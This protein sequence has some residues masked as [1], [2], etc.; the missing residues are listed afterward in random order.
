MTIGSLLIGIAI[1]GFL[2]P[3]RLLDGG[4]VG[5]ALILHYYFDFRTGLWTALLSI[6]LSVYAWFHERKQF[7][8][9]FQGM[10]MTSLFIDIL[11]PLSHQISLPIWLSSVIGG[12]VSGAGIGLMLRYKTSTGGT[13]LLAY[14]I[15][16]ATP[17]NIGFLIFLIDGVIVLAGYPTLGFESLLFSTLTIFI[18]GWVASICY[19]R[20]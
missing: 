8:G 19:E 4:I 17:L 5:I 7:Y 16:K 14:F 11:A 12:V 9:S 13:D 10:L 6:P 15:S 18:A 1:N 2:V 3:H 20:I